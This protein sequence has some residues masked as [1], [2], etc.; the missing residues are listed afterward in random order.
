MGV[1]INFSVD[2][3]NAAITDVAHS[4]DAAGNGLIEISLTSPNAIQ[5]VDVTAAAPEAVAP[6][7]ETPAPDPVPPAPVT[8]PGQF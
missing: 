2:G 4:V 6:P 8:D 1:T 5:P 3:R 7:A